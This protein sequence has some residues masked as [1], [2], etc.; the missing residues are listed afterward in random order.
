MTTNWKTLTRRPSWGEA[1]IA[2][3]EAQQRGRSRLWVG[4]VLALTIALGLLSRRYPL[5][6]ILAEYTG[7]ALYA[8]AAFVG[9]ALL[10][11]GRQTRTLAILAFV[12]CVLI[13]FTQLLNW[14]W[15]RDLRSTTLGKLLLGSG[16]K[17]PDMLAYLIG[18]IVAATVDRMARRRHVLSP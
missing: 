14:I 1:V 5:P 10:L 12:S 16:F 4:V 9:F 3:A 18:V 15:I 17:W 8:S 2:P 13:E 11:A 6:G 7:D